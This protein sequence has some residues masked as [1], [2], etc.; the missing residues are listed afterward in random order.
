[1]LESSAKVMRIETHAERI[2]GPFE[3]GLAGELHLKARVG[4]ATE[5]CPL[6]V[7]AISHLRAAVYGSLLEVWKVETVPR[8]ADVAAPPLRPLPG[9]GQV[10]VETAEV[11][12]AKRG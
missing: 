3:R 1:M 11:A 8:E 2:V 9:P 12:H 4:C 6:A 7:K 10:G 5:E